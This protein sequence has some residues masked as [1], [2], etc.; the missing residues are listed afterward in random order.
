MNSDGILLTD[1]L[2]K[3][4]GEYYRLNKKGEA[5][6]LD[7]QM[8]AAAAYTMDGDLLQAFQLAADLEYYGRSVF[9][10]TWTTKELSQYGFTNKKGNCYVKSAMFCNMAIAMGYDAHMTTG[11]VKV[12]GGWGR[13]GWVEIIVNGETFVCDPYV[14]YRFGLQ[15]SYFI[16]YGDRGTYIYDE[17][18]WMD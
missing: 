16:H 8:A 5:V 14:R 6:L 18:V 2:F 10:K 1:Q 11:Y 12:E 4:K 15:G 9:N 17:P 3:W 13:H 7:D